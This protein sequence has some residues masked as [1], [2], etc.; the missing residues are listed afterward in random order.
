MIEGK[1]SRRGLL[2]ATGLILLA[3]CQVVPKGAPQSSGPATQVPNANVLP[4]DQQRHRVAILLPTS[5][6]NAGVGQALANAAN[7]AVLDT[8]ATNL[9]IT[10]YDTSSGTADA[11]T[12]AIADGNKL[13]L[14]PLMGD[15]VVAVARIARPARV[16]IIAFSNDASVAGRDVFIMGSLPNQSIERTIGWAR[17][18]GARRFGALLPEGD[19]GLRAN[20]ALNTAVMEA[21]GTVVASEV[22]A[23]SN[24]SIISAAKRLKGKGQMDA[25]LIA[26]G[27]RF[28]VLAAPQLRPRG[29]GPRLLGTELWSGDN[30]ALTSPS[31]RGAWYA[32][33]SDGRFLQFSESYRN[34]FGAQP[35]RMATMGYDAVLLTLRVARTWKPGTTFPTAKLQDPEGFLGLDGVFRFGANGVVERALEVVEIRQGGVTVVSPAPARLPN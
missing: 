5:G 7:M 35:H 26:D 20:A 21:G 6:P 13:I 33:P 14:G 8:N 3:G 27:S 25:V 16:P 9:R 29:V 30:A 10:T 22:F 11:A 17:S 23:R 19:Y 28:A 15:E 18:K 4:A 24:P 12:R 2:A 34:R 1:F 31:M 32:A